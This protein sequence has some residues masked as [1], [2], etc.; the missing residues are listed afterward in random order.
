MGRY[1]CRSIWCTVGRFSFE[2]VQ[3]LVL[4]EVSGKTILFFFVASIIAVLIGWI[5]GRGIGW[6]FQKGHI[7]SI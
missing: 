1:Y 5:L 4:R 6:M 3:F 7:Q 2:I